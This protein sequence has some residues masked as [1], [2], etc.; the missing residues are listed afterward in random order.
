MAPIFFLLKPEKNGKSPLDVPCLN[1]KLSTALLC[2]S[3]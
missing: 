2:L 3:I 1:L